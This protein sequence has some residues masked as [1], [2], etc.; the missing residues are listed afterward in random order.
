MKGIF[1]TIEGPDGAGK[2]SVIEAI[3][4]KLEGYFNK[5]IIQTREPG[6]SPIA[7]KI[8]ELILDIN[9][10]EMDDRTESLLYAASR[11]QH[12]VEKIR[13]AL[14][15][16]DIVLCDRFVDSSLAYQGA[17]RELSIEKVWKINE[18]AIE[19]LRP[20][21][22][23]Y[24]D[25]EAEVGLNRIADKRSNRKKDR[26][27]LEDISF[28]NKVREGYQTLIKK[29]PERFIVIDA[30]QPKDLVA[31]EAWNLLVEQLAEIDN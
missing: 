19:D 29:H 26:L 6:G 13:P 10:S 7:E 31:R 14:E 25:V 12:V 2:S 9:H 28:H 8:R 23:L 3:K 22:T 24:L 16:G 27:E 5:P 17:G 21:L 15:R 4:P 30:N 18:F 11:R 1:I 20:D